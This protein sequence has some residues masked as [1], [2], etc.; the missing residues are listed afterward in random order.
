MDYN[1]HNTTLRTNK[2]LNFEERFYLEKR[3]VLGDSIAAISRSL[4]RSRTTIYTE[5]KR[6]TVIQIR[7]GKSQLV[8]LADSGQATYE[9]QRVGS[10]NTM[11]IGA[12]E[13]F[14]NWI[15][16]KTLVDHWS[17]DAAVGYAKHKGLFMRNEMVCTKTL[18]NYLHQGLLGVK[19]I[20]LPLVTRRS[21][22]KSVSS[23]Y[24]RELGKIN[25]TS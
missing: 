7:Q 24:K 4:G 10:F 25:R 9:R 14:I 22:R 11:R 20:D 5:L 19:A 15:E 17:F 16:S 2:H 6:G 21:L 13:S 18:Y 1:N 8:Y 23:K 12:I 3:I